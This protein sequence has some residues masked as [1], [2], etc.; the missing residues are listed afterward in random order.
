MY[1]NKEYCFNCKKNVLRQFHWRSLYIHTNVCLK[2]CTENRL[3]NLPHIVKRLIKIQELYG[4]PQ[5]NIHPFVERDDTSMQLI[6]MLHKHNNTL[7][8][9]TLNQRIC[10]LQIEN[11][12]R[13]PSE[14]SIW[15][16]II[17]NDL[18]DTH[19]YVEYSEIDKIKGFFANN[20]P[21]FNDIPDKKVEEAEK[22]SC[23]MFRNMKI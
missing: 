22:D 3:I 2:C 23:D 10:F 12:L 8:L 5:M 11:T 13:T 17:T 21:M 16:K 19:G 20:L 6:S 15:N 18:L 1:T 9:E 7:A 4:N 14:L